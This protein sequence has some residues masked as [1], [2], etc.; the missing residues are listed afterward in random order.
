[1]REEDDRCIEFVAAR[2]DKRGQRRF[3]LS[4]LEEVRGSKVVKNNGDVKRGL[5]LFKS[6]KLI[7]T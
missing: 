5:F 7:L 2:E 1:L 6:L 3:A 4:L